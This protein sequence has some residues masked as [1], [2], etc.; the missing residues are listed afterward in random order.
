MIDRFV[1]LS[2]PLT[3]ALLAWM[4]FGTQSSR[5][6]STSPQS[7]AEKKGLYEASADPSSLSP[8]QGPFDSLPVNRLPRPPFAEQLAASDRKVAPLALTVVSSG[9]VSAALGTAEWLAS[10][11]L[12][13][14]GCDTESTG[15]APADGAVG[16]FD[17][18]C[19]RDLNAQVAGHLHI[20]TLYS[21]G[22]A[23]GLYGTDYSRAIRVYTGAVESRRTRAADGMSMP[24][25]DEVKLLKLEDWTAFSFEDW[26]LTGLEK[27]ADLPFTE[28]GVHWAAFRDGIL[29]VGHG[30][31]TYAKSSGGKNAFLS[32]LDVK[33]GKLLW[34]SKPLVANAANF[35]ILGDVIISG[36]GFTAEKDFLYQINRHTG[37]VLDRTPLPTGPETIVIRGDQL[38]VKAY[39][40]EHVWRITTK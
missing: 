26:M 2:Q 29:Y 36:Y 6:E 19:G 24:A 14:P 11:E 16:A 1:A 23:I 8:P 25:D 38:I 28:Q 7:E 22:R 35:V 12:P 39:S 33:S 32:A 18:P 15:V 5:A 30:H 27:K 31:R 17:P 20:A 9:K 37:A 21:G 34:Q 4:A 10:K 40:S 13:R 3:I